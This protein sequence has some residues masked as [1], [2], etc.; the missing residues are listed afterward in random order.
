VGFAAGTEVALIDPAF[1]VVKKGVA[2]EWF[3]IE[4]EG[5]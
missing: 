2:V 4:I 1:A 5:S 3:T